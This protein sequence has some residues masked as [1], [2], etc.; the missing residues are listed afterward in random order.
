MLRICSN[1]A[2]KLDDS[3]SKSVGAA[4]V[5]MVQLLLPLGVLECY[6]M[7]ES[8]DFQLGFQGGQ[9]VAVYLS[10]DFLY[11][12]FDNLWGANEVGGGY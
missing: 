10:P 4:L 7:Y 12:H 6:V 1:C 9:H 2:I 5:M 8:F 11:H 3:L